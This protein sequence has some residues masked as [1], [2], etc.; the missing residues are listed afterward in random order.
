MSGKAS[1]TCF[2]AGVKVAL[3]SIFTRAG[4]SDPP[5]AAAR[6]EGHCMAMLPTL[7][8]PSVSRA[9]MRAQAKALLQSAP[10]SQDVAGGFAPLLAAM[11]LPPGRE[12]PHRLLRFAFMLRYHLV[13]EGLRASASDGALMLEAF[14]EILVPLLGDR[15]PSAQHL[16]RS[17]PPE[18]F[19]PPGL[20]TLP[21]DDAALWRAEPLRLRARRRAARKQIR[22]R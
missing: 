13:R 22:A 20:V 4:V 11:K 12:P 17:L 21:I 7:Q 5:A 15:A 16:L 14:E 1:A 3:A 18:I 10:H 9:Q 19:P 8:G 2:P 6:I